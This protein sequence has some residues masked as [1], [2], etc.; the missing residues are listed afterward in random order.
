MKSDKIQVVRSGYNLI[1]DAYA[2]DRATFGSEKYLRQLMKLIRPGG[3][4]LD[5]GCGDGVPVDRILLKNGYQV[6]GVDL[7]EKQIERAKRNCPEAEYKVGDLGELK[8]D[9]YQ[10]EAIVC[11]YTM[12]HIPRSS[13]GERLKVMNSYLPKGGVMLVSMGDKEFE[14]MTKFHGQPMWWSQWGLKKN[15]EL[16]EKAGLEVLIDEVDH[17]GGEK[18]QMILARK[19]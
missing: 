8:E 6:V 16:V 9:E 10:V 17:T 1:G 2:Q 4:I 11:L 15:R 13:H 18:H 5:L 7:A 19:F 3:T 14:G 12:F